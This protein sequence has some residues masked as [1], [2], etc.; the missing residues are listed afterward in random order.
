MPGYYETRNTAL[1][2]KNDGLTLGELFDWFKDYPEGDM[3][4]IHFTNF[5]YGGITE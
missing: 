2:A 3:G 4:I 5:R 1:V